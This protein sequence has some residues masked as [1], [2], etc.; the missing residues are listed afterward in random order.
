VQPLLDSIAREYRWPG[1]TPWVPGVV[2]TVWITSRTKG[3]D[4]GL[5]EDRRMRG[6]RPASDFRPA[7]SNSLGY[8]LLGDGRV[9]DAIRVFQLNVELYPQ[10]ANAYDSLGE[11]FMTAGRNELAIANYRRWLELDP[12]NENAVTNLRKLGVEWTR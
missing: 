11:G 12:K 3:L 7:Q 10:D 9:E 2:D 1:Y 6:A 8:Q 4:A 5:A